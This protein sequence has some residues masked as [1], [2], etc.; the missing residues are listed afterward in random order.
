MSNE[1]LDDNAWAANAPFWIK[2]IR[3]RLDRYRTELTDPAV[4]EG[5]G[6]CHG[7]SVLDAGCGEGY[8]SRAVAERGASRVVGID[9]CEELILAARELPPQG[10]DYEFKTADIRN[11]PYP[12]ATFDLIVANHSI[13]EVPDPQ[14]AFREFA[15]VVKPDGQLVLLMLHPCFFTWSGGDQAP[16]D[17]RH[18]RIGQKPYNVADIASPA[19][20]TAHVSTLETYLD[21]LCQN[22]FTLTAVR[23]LKPSPQQVET[24][25]WWH[26]RAT[27]PRF[28][29]VKA[30]PDRR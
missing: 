12:A 13:N 26:E 22:G 21:G 25:P 9:T 8:L 10:T 27:P 30:Q 24:D 5:V 18:G 23:E 16:T 6:N 15:R 19:V 14:P 29:L 2:I 17:Y 20:A 1:P 3:E 11:I 7:Q 28:L 4:L